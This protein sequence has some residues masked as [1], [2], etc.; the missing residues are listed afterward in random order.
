MTAVNINQLYKSYNGKPAVEDLTFSVNSGELLG[1]IGPNGAGKST[2][3]KVLLDFIKPD[4]GEV[5][6]FGEPMNETLKNKLG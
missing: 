2:T 3:I 1:L 4:S 6:I 5:S